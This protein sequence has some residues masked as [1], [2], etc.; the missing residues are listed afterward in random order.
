MEVAASCRAMAKRYRIVTTVGDHVPIAVTYIASSVDR[1]TALLDRARQASRAL[2]V[3]DAVDDYRRILLTNSHGA[4]RWLVLGPWLEFPERALRSAELQD[5]VYDLVI[6]PS[7]LVWNAALARVLTIWHPESLLVDVGRTTAGSYDL[8]LWVSSLLI[9][10]R[11]LFPDVPLSLFCSPLSPASVST[12]DMLPQDRTVHPTR[13]VGRTPLLSVQMVTDEH[14][15]LDSLRAA[16]HLQEGR[17][18]VVASTRRTAERIVEVV[19]RDKHTPALLH[20]GLSVSEK[21]MALAAYREG[22]SPIL[23]CTEALVVE[24][25]LPAPDVI[26]VSHPPRWPELAVALLAWAKPEA[27]VVFLYLTADLAA[28]EGRALTDLPTLERTRAVYRALRARAGRGYALVNSR[29]LGKS[30]GSGFAAHP[31]VVRGALL[32]LERCGFLE[33]QEDFPRGGSLTLEG[34]PD[35]TLAAI[36]RAAHLTAGVPTPIQPLELAHRVGLTPDALQRALLDADARGAMLLKAVALDMLYMLPPPPD[37]GGYHLRA[38]IRQI[39]ERARWSSRLVTGFLTGSGCRLRTLHTAFGLPAGPRCGHC[40][41]CSSAQ[42]G[43]PTKPESNA[44]LAL[45]ALVVIP[46]GVPRATALRA[47]RGALAAGGRTVD[48]Q[49]ASE[50]LDELVQRHLLAR[51]PGSLVDLV[52][53]SEQGVQALALHQV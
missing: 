46:L 29:S 11:A 43:P 4:G 37:R 15:R 20:G 27:A 51:R 53:V 16:L 5:G 50:L 52:Q 21:A 49:A 3:T 42:E 1:A 48:E 9:R 8:K 38:A 40:D 22:R 44:Y 28:L 25:G 24:P 30:L 33:R 45:R 6:L 35:G 26:L 41:I 14:A 12:L 36:A 2:A 17:A 31:S 13:L 7:S 47:V 18:V 39:E 19:S 23:V 10:V 34:T 32:L